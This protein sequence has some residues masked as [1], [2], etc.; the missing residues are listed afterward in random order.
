VILIERQDGKRYILSLTAGI[1]LPDQRSK[2]FNV[3]IKSTFASLADMEYYDKDCQAH[4][5]LKAVVGPTREDG[6]TVYF[7]SAL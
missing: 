6:L 4:K 1:P 3:A 5:L 7:E 2:G